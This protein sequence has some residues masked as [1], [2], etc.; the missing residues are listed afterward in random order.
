MVKINIKNTEVTE[1]RI[2]DLSYNPVED[3]LEK[4]RNVI[5]STRRI[6]KYLNLPNKKVIFY[7][8]NSHNILN[9]KPGDVGSGRNHLEIYSYKN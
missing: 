2:I 7:A 9:N 6:S 3:F 5:Y 4:N 1:R 8:K